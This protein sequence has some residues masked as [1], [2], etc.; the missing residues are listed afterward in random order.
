MLFGKHTGQTVKVD[1]EGLLIMREE[2]TMGIIETHA[3][4]VVR[5]AWNLEPLTDTAR[6]DTVNRPVVRNVL[7]QRLIWDNKYECKRR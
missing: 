3:E 1:G 5:V 6:Q 2:D 4:A 7:G